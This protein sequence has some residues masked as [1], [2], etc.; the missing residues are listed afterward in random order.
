MGEARFNGNRMVK[1]MYR[2]K[3]ISEHVVGNQLNTG[4]YVKGLTDVVREMC[5]STGSMFEQEHLRFIIYFAVTG[6]AVCGGG[7]KY[8]KTIMERKVIQY[9]RAENG[10]KSLFR[11]WHHKFTTALGHVSSAHEGIVQ[12]LVKEIG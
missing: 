8:Q 6:G 9:L 10:D 1:G 12:R 11:Q 5:M 7:R 2:T 3:E 4:K